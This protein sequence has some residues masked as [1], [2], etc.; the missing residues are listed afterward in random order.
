GPSS[1]PAQRK[2]ARIA[3]VETLGWGAATSGAKDAM[4]GAVARC[5]AAGIEVITR[6]SNAKVAAVE[7]A[8]MEARGASMRLNAW[9][10]RWPLN[11][12]RERDASKLSRVMLDRLTEA[13]AMSLDD[14]RRDLAQ[15][16]RDRALYAEL[17]S[18]CEACISL[19]APSAAPM[20]L[21]S[22][23]DPN[24]TVHAS[25]LGIPAISLPVLQDEGLPLGLQI[26]GFINGDAQTFA[27][28]AALKALF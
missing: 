15:R 6:Q 3:F 23:G 13:E 2:P 26:A 7:T 5:R 18:E 9:E 24:C 17:A 11:A 25:L 4:A 21:D 14:Y 16:D 12:Y 27:T 22:T 8:I 1:V 28:A 20:G 19:S 10:W